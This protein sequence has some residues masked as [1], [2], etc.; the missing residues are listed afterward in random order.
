MRW[1]CILFPQLSLS[2][3][4]AVLTKATCLCC[5]GLSG[6]SSSSASRLLMLRIEPSGVRNS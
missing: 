3:R 1:V 2:S 5:S 4:A 6:P